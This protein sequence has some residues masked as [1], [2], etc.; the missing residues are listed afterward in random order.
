MVL[1]ASLCLSAGRQ[2]EASCNQIPGTTNIFRGFAGSLNRPFAGPG[3]AVDI[4]LS[5]TCDRALLLPTAEDHAVTVV[6]K[7]PRGPRTVVVLAADCAGLQQNLRACE[8]LASVAL[9]RCVATGGT[10]LVEIIE[11]DGTRRLRFRFPDTDVDLAAPE[12]DRTLAGPAVIA[13]TAAGAA[14]PCALAEEACG[15]AVEAIACID[16]LHAVSGSCDLTGGAEFPHF[17]ALPPANDFQ[18]LCRQPSPPCRG[19][20]APLRFT[21]DVEGNALL[22]MDWRGILVGEGIPIARLL[23]GS[24]SFEAFPDVLAPI[25]IAR[26]SHL[27]SFSP[28]GGKLPPIFTPQSSSGDRLTLFGSAD[29][30]ETVLRIARRV[31]DGGPRADMLCTSDDHCP[32][33]ACG[34][35]IFDFSTRFDSSVGA[36]LVAADQH[37]LEAR[38]PVPLDALIETQNLF[39]FVVPEPISDR[40]SGP[41]DLNEDGD[42]EDEVLLIMDPVSG[43][44]IPS[45]EGTAPGRAAAR[46]R[47]PP[48]SFPAVEAAGEMVV[49]LEP[50]IKQGAVDRTADGDVLDAIL[51]VFRVGAS[52]GTELTA[53]SRLAVDTAPLVNGRVVAMAGQQLFFRRREAAV[54]ARSIERANVASNGAQSAASTAVFQPALNRDGNVVAFQSTASNLLVG[55]EKDENGLQ[56]I[57][58][59]DRRLGFTSRASVASSGAEAND[60]S[61]WPALSA[62]GRLVAFDSNAD[63]TSDTRRS[64]DVYIHD[65]NTG[66][67]VSLDNDRREPS[68]NADGT[69]IA[70]L[71]T[72]NNDVVVYQGGRGTTAGRN[73]SSATVSA[74]GQVVAYAT[75]G[76]VFA[77]DRRNG[78]TTRV[79]V[80]SSGE[81][82]NRPSGSPSISGNGLHIAFHSGADNLVAGDTN[83]VFDVFVRDLHTRQTERVSVS[84]T[85]LQANAASQRPRI[86]EDGRFVLFESAATNLSPGGSTPGLYLHDRTTGVTEHIVQAGGFPHALSGNGLTV[87]F[88][89]PRSD[90]VPGDTNAARDLFV[91]SPIQPG[92]PITGAD[93]TG[94]GD[95]EDTVLETMDVSGVIETL[96]PAS[97][98][99][100]M[101]A[102]AAFLEPEGATNPITA[103][104][105]APGSGLP[106][107]IDSLPGTQVASSLEVTNNGRVV[108][109]DVVGLHITHPFVRD[110]VVRLRSPA[111]TVVTLTSR[112]GFDGDDYI[113]TTFDDEAF[114][115]IAS[116]A[117]PFTGIFKPLGRLSSFRGE[118][119]AGTW[120]LEVEDVALE[121]MGVLN[122]WALRLL[123]DGSQ[124]LNLDGDLDDE[125]VQLYDPSTGVENLALAATQLALGHQFL[126]VLVSERQQGGSDLDGDLDTND[127]VLHVFDVDGGTGIN[128]R[129]SADTVQISG[130]LVGLITPEAGVGRRG[131]DLNADGDTGDRVLQL[132]DAEARRLLAVVDAAG[133]RQ[134]VE[135]MVLGPAV[136]H[137]GE[138]SGAVCERPADCGGGWCGPTLVALRTNE[139]AQN[140]PQQP[141][142]D[143]RRHLLQVYDV[144]NRRLVNTGQTVVPC[145]FEAC[146]PRV[147]YRVRLNTV[148]FLTSEP[149]QQA[150][151][152]GD[153]D[154]TDLV[155]QTYNVGF[156]VG[157]APRTGALAAR[158][159]GTLSQAACAGRQVAAPVLTLGGVSLGVCTTTSAPCAQNS[160]CPGGTCF[161]P[162][163]GCILQ[164]EDQ[165]CVPP[166]SPADPPACAAGDFC[167]RSTGSQFRCMR[168]VGPCESSA[169]CAAIPACFGASCQCRDEAQDIQRLIGPLAG[170]GTVELFPSGVGRC[171]RV[172]ET[173]CSQNEDCPRG[174]T[175]GT[176]AVCLETLAE[177]SR[178]SDCPQNAFCRRELVIASALDSDGDEIPDPCDNCAGLPNLDQ[179][180]SDGDGVGDA[181]DAE[182]IVPTPTLPTAATPSSSPTP[183]STPEPTLTATQTATETPP[184]LPTPAPADTATPTWTETPEDT[185][186]QQSSPTQTPVSPVA[187]ANCDGRRSAADLSATI[188]LL[189]S[190]EMAP[191]GIDP[192]QL[193][194]QG[195]L[196]AIF[197]IP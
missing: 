156:G 131:T 139:A 74:D 83:G 93:L 34:A 23:R 138:R 31:C 124:D 87:A 157:M 27:A 133:R 117:A 12:D 189:A 10:D 174:Q 162:P 175:C 81:T 86:S 58:V 186:T 7:P 122:A 88:E 121:D 102:R 52:G 146:D 48:F 45:G 145:A 154:A 51:R 150:D 8:A 108:D 17:T 107:P 172:T 141:P 77:F 111:G 167:A 80:A 163:G 177:C 18:G 101:G 47:Q 40:G 4:R 115:T 144:R 20:A 125:V 36:V 119:A 75:A 147:P 50:E 165:P 44:V 55:T 5:P 181:C 72:N 16:T 168:V 91:S 112:L 103:G 135:E 60:R 68:M 57:F 54:A 56:D 76:Q 65:R 85:G 170:D 183:A 33:T 109:V 32:E 185:R 173:A 171:T 155:L 84:S 188:R 136:C 59:R 66:S 79:D 197:A 21:I 14:L 43:E 1:L 6:F 98:A 130:S 90:L 191:C 26:R 49:F 2:A 35:P 29:A 134:A 148:T 100:V 61:S 151:L 126:A 38:D 180:D 116:A 127:L 22:P 140:R 73:A 9:T 160:D 30:P 70:T 187:D 63:L 95:L 62:D 42:T 196:A 89:S 113:G 179:I 3:D 78:V 28:L 24:T 71:N 194:V 195:T 99:T 106:L 118:T 64:R 142:I 153:G 192:A 11:S 97:L 123:L 37:A 120:T 69:V 161:L 190:G 105:H 193:G 96:G 46:I 166:S 176:R 158:T 92:D 152:N 104:T 110:L 19:I 143:P 164:L 114:R 53:G 82:A 128:T 39:A 159:A 129:L 13:V 169:D 149:I 178:D 132:Y 184:R 15:P 182:T 25:H 41:A 137:G 94:D 67:T